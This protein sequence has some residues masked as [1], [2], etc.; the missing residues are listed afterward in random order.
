LVHFVRT[1]LSWYQNHTEAL[2]G[3]TS[4]TQTWYCN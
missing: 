2:Q 4:G 3:G 1:I